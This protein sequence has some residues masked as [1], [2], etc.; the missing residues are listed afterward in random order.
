MAPKCRA[1]DSSTCKNH[2]VPITSTSPTN[3]E[4]GKSEFFGASVWNKVTAMQEKSH[5]NGVVRDTMTSAFN[6]IRGFNKGSGSYDDKNRKYIVETL[7]HPKLGFVKNEGDP[8]YAAE[9]VR[10]KLAE[11]DSTSNEGAST[12]ATV[13]LFKALGREDEISPGMETKAY[14]HAQK[15]ALGASFEAKAEAMIH[16]LNK[17]KVFGGNLEG[18]WLNSEMR[19]FTSSVRD[20]A[21]GKDSH[22]SLELTYR[23]SNVRLWVDAKVI[24]KEVTITKF[25]ATDHPSPNTSMDYE[26]LNNDLVGIFYDEN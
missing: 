6:D 20:Q 17:H 21:T 2:G 26:G 12:L 9:M 25:K 22:N 15:P 3:D 13:R 18:K 23:G 1:K 4:A 7:T 8:S 24:D 10:E 19:S 11:F 14:A 5:T 16:V